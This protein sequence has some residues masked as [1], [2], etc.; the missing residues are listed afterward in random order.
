MGELSLYS[1]IS[2]GL[3]SSFYGVI[4]WTIIKSGAKAN[5]ATWISWLLM[6][7][8]ILAGML[9]RKA[10]VLLIATYTLGTLLVVIVCALGRPDFKWGQTE[11]VCISLVVVV[12]VVW[13][14]T[15]SAEVAICISL[16]AITIGSFPMA[17]GLWENPANEK[18]LPW[19]LV[20]LGTFFSVLDI[21]NWTFVQAATPVWCL[22]LQ[23][24]TVWLIT[25]RTA[26]AV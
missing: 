13:A 3:V 1:W 20:A 19:V 16:V 9:Q 22:I 24:T 6:D 15:G 17:K 2:L 7:L 26:P 5:L 4:S 18:L 10:D 25:R 23:S 11:K 8:A 12:I 21:K 14:L